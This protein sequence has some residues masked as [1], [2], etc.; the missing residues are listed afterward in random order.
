MPPTARVLA[1]AALLFFLLSSG[2]PLARTTAASTAQQISADPYTNTT[3]QHETEVEPDTYAHG[4]TVVAA[5]QVGRFTNGG[6]SNIGWATSTDAGITWTHGYLASL[7]AFA[8]PPGS[9]GR[10]SD[11]SVA[12]DETL[13]VWLIASL[14]LTSG[15]TVIGIVVSQSVGRRAS[16]SPEWRCLSGRSSTRPRPRLDV[17]D[18]QE[19]VINGAVHRH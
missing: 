3:S 19:A 5:F 18:R 17:T 9:A 14:T 13:G 4:S 11:P 15:G 1:L 6:A 2:P 10:A 16:D 7:T 12:Y 8:T